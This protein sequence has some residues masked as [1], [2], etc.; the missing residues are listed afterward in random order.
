[1]K[2][3][4]YSVLAGFV[5]MIFITGCET[6][7]ELVLSGSLVSHSECKS[8]LQTAF[9]ISDTPDSLSC[10]EYS[11]DAI[12]NKLS[13]THVNAGFNCCQDSLYCS[14]TSSND[15][16]IIQEYEKNPICR[17][18]CV[19]DLFIEVDGIEEGKYQIKFIEPYSG[20][21]EPLLFEIDLKKETEGSFC[22]VRKGSPW[23]TLSVY[24]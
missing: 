14:I 2:R 4:V 10:V 24:Q 9:E 11:F 13:L 21:M 6:A 22:V 5:F 16:I 18:S 3:T 17:C 1:M 19:Y 23:G 7:K 20:D 15:T 8:G 12:N